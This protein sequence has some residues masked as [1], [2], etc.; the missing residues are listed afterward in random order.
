MRAALPI[1]CILIIL[2]SCKSDPKKA[3]DETAA[4]LENDFL[5]VPGERVGIITGETTEETVEDFFGQE[6]VKITSLYMGE[7]AERE[8]VVVFP[9]TEN[10]IEIVWEL[11]ANIGRPAFVRL[12]KENSAW[13]TKQGVRVGM[14][15][16]ALEAIN[17]QPFTFYGFEWD[18]GGLVT[19]WNNGK[20]SPY[21][22]VALMPQDFDALTPDL[23]GEVV[24]SSDDPKVRAV[25]PK[26]GSMVVTFY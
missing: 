26:I 24:L 20:L 9:G 18:F 6:N 3:T 25:A 17:G 1:F 23:L 11:A 7:E 22:V 4:P 21:L 19:D 2:F 16:E 10:E 14:T 13:K 12:N 5:I 8:G 15:L